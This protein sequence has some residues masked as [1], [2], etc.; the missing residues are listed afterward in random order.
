MIG[1]NSAL[2]KQFPLY[3]CRLITMPA[4][5]KGGKKIPTLTADLKTFIS[6]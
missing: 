6:L 5:N 2:P 1:S 4:I 3:T